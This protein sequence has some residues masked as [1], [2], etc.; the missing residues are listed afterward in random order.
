MF[1]KYCGKEVDGDIAVCLECQE[2][3]KGFCPYCGNATKTSSRFCEHCD[4]FLGN[5]QTP[6]KTSAPKKTMATT[7]K[8]VNC[9]SDI[10]ASSF[11]CPVCGRMAN[12]ISPPTYPT[13]N[14]GSFLTGFLLVFFLGVIGLIIAYCSRQEDTKRGAKVTFLVC[15]LIVLLLFGIVGCARIFLS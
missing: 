14:Q 8:C 13:S 2:N 3:H 6:K 11:Y 7:K 4:A 10:P 12:T 5:T 9:R 15:F 1:C